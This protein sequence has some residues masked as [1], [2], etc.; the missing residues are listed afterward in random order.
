MADIN[1][2]YVGEVIPVEGTLKT[3][4]VSQLFANMLTMS[5]AVYDR[6]E[7][8]TTLTK[9]A[10]DIIQGP[11]TDSYHYEIDTT[12]YEYGPITVIITGTFASSSVESGIANDIVCKKK[13]I[14]LHKCP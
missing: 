8:R 1:Y 10:S 11:T 3:N 13:L 4:G 9:S 6:K 12:G 5:V 7:L 14:I 2:N